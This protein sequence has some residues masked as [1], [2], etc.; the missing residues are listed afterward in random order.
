MEEAGMTKS[1]PETFDFSGFNEP[2]R[3]E[4]EIFDL[5]IEGAVP[6]EINGAWFRLTPDHAFPPML[7][8]DT[9]ISGD[10]MISRF[11]FEDGHVDYRQRYVRTERFLAERK[12]RR[13]LFGLYRNPYTDDPSV[14][15]KGRGVA[16]TT[17]VWHGGKLLCLKEDSRAVEVDPDTLETKG[18]WDYDGKLKSETMTAHTRLDPDTGELHFYGY[19]ADGLASRQIAYC[20]AD[21]KG[22]L[23]REEW[24]EAPFCSQVHDFLVTKRHVIFPLFP[25]TADLDRLK[26][27]GVHWVHEQDKNA[28]IGI[29]PRDASTKE[30]RWFTG[31]KGVS[32]YHFMNAFSEGE[33]VHMDFGVI[34]SN[35][36]PFIR[37]ASGLPMDPSQL[38]GEYV[39]WSF[40]LSKREDTYQRRVLGPAGDM[41]RIASKDFMR[42]YE[43]GYYESFDPTNAPPLIAGPVGAGF[44]TI[45]RLN[46][47]TGELRRLPMDR[48]ST[49]EEA[50]HIPSKQPGHEGYLAFAVDLH[51]V[52]GSE[53]WV[54]DAAHPEKGAMAKIKL[55]LRLR[56]QVHGNWVNQEEF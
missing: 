32:S 36:F 18:E 4:C 54:V 16:N 49:L 43:I 7:G 31:P 53:V 2:S 6:K 25:T 52:M 42:D 44:N 41:P 23:I 20:V 55:P 21:K 27:G 28:A 51:D 38:R 10:G 40:D 47:K 8:H 34:S 56:P 14:R 17:P 35:P 26:A 13:G 33:I 39:R 46:V 5:E 19:E 50:I 30:M 3:V 37:E 24:F 15:G 48:R 12:A 9:L 11:S 1:F 22:K 29:M 45:Q